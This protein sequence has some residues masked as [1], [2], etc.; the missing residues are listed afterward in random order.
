MW[1]GSAELNVRPFFSTPAFID[2]C[3]T[4]DDDDAFLY[5][6]TGAVEVEAVE[7]SNGMLE[8]LE[9]KAEEEPPFGPP[10]GED[11]QENEEENGEN[12]VVEDEESDEDVCAAWQSR[13]AC[14]Q[15][16]PRISK[17]SWNQLHAHL[18]SGEHIPFP[19]LVLI[20]A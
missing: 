19:R 2:S 1:V 6:E 10:P 9:A 16:F 7:P 14:S 12:G 20:Q 8:N 18:I 15:V 11:E 3:N 17:S 13:Y 4:R 5:G